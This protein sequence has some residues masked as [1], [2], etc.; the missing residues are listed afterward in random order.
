M[1]L[2]VHSGRRLFL[3]NVC[4]LGTL[5]SETHDENF[6]IYVN[7]V[8]SDTDEEETGGIRIWSSL[9][10]GVPPQWRSATPVTF[11]WE[12]EDS[13]DDGQDI[14]PNS[15]RVSLDTSRLHQDLVSI[16]QSELDSYRLSSQF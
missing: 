11:V 13:D 1:V 10:S 4:F 16:D 5:A 2:A 8:S 6:K 12:Q 7:S 14:T 9:S 15:K 3:P